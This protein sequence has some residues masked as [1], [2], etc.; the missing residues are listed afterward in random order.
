MDKT[1]VVSAIIFI[2]IVVFT[3]CQSGPTPPQT[4]AISDLKIKLPATTETASSAC[5]SPKPQNIG[6]TTL[7]KPCVTWIC[8]GG[9]WERQDIDTSEL[10]KPSGTSG[11]IPPT[12]C[13]R[14]ATGFCPAECSFCF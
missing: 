5:P 4:T 8:V 9:K 10:C 6:C 13:P 1:Y 14:T 3:G 7:C 11:G 12:A 2:M